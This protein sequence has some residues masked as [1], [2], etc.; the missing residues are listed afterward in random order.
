MGNEYMDKAAFGDTISS[1]HLEA[2]IAF[3]H[4]IA[5]SFEKTNWNRILEL[6]NWLC[7]VAPS[8]ITELNRVVVIMQ[9]NGPSSALQNLTEMADQKKLESYYLYYSLLGEINSRLHNSNEAK[10]NFEMAL[11]LTQSMM[12]K[13]ILLDKIENLFN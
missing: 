10:R 8:P 9:V 5:E 13:K 4:C 2:A 1:Y 11:K 12:E 3:E 7:K 6:Y